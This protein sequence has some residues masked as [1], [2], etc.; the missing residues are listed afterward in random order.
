MF[1]PSLI[2]LFLVWMLR[3]KLTRSM[4]LLFVPF[5]LACIHIKWSL[6]F[7]VWVLLF[8]CMIISTYCII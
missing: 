2:H 8:C 6:I 3:L 1:F 7:R 4:A 5:W